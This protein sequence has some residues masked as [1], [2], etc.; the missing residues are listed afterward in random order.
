MTKLLEVELLEATG[1]GNR[2]SF[3]Q[4]HERYAGVLFSAAYQV[5]NDP[6]R[7]RGRAPGHL[8]ADLGQGQALRPHP[9]QAADLGV[10][11]HAQQV[12]RPAA[13]R[14]TPPPAQGRGGKREPPSSSSAARAVRRRAAIR[15]SGC[16]RGRPTSSCAMR[17][18]NFPTNSGRP[19]RWRSSADLTQNEIAQRLDEPLG[20]VKARIRRGHAQA[21][22]THRAAALSERMCAA[23][24]QAVVARYRGQV[25]SPL[26]GDPDSRDWRVGLTRPATMSRRRD[27]GGWPSKLRAP[28]REQGSPRRGDPTLLRPARRGFAH[29]FRVRTPRGEASVRSGRLARP[30]LLWSADCL[31]FASGPAQENRCPRPGRVLQ[32]EYPVRIR[33]VRPLCCAGCVGVASLRRSRSVS[34]MSAV[35]SI[36]VHRACPGPV[37]VFL[38]GR[39]QVFPQGH[40]LRP[41]SSRRRRGLRRHAGSA[42]APTSRSCANWASTCCASTTSRR[43]GSW[44]CWPRPGCS[45]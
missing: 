41:V 45:C 18:C 8:R 16:T 4:L 38:P 25:G 14:P 21:Q 31:R 35:S 44:T 2:D 24:P 34:S 37:Q 27:Q 32:G 28:A 29:G 17:C 42:S 36:P 1:R 22:G 40:H 43:A 7:S 33:C 20:T 11:P 10:D 3:R 30:S 15:S 9:R 13:Q 23:P 26:R 5:L 19:L 39:A 6:D 12:H